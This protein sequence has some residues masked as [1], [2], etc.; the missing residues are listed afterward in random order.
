MEQQIFVPQT[1]KEAENIAALAAYLG[2]IY[3]GN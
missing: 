3:Y 2:S 1:A